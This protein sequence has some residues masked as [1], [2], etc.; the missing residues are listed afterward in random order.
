MDRRK[1]SVFAILLIVMILCFKKISVS[2]IDVA[3]PSD[4]AIY[5]DLEDGEYSIGVNLTGG[6]GKASVLSP[7]LL[8]IE[9]ARAYVRLVWSSSNYDYMIVDGIK[10]VNEAEEG[11]DSMFTV[12]VLAMDRAYSVIGDTTAMGTPHEITY[13]LTLYSDTIDSKSALPQEAAK[14]VVVIALII[15]VGG[16]ILNAVLKKKYRE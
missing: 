10:Y 7:S 1:T 8:I 9:D 14:K 15:I 12:P 5:L 16:G 6:S 13:E 4:N 3:P 11:A 2:A